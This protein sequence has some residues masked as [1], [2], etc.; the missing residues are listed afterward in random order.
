MDARLSA[1]AWIL[2]SGCFGA[3]VGTLFG[4]VAGAL[5]WRSGR[6]SGTRLSLGFAETVRRFAGREFSRPAKG[7]LIGA[8]DGFLFLG[9]VGTVVGALAVYGGRPPADLLWPAM[10]LTL[11]LVGLAAFFG[12]LAYTLTR[13]GVRGLAPVAC[14]GVLGAAL[15]W[16]Q[17]GVGGLL[18][19]A[20]AGIAVGNVLGLLWPRR[21]EPEFHAPR[22]EMD[23]PYPNGP[24]DGIQGPPGVERPPE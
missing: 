17:G 13:A 18:Y 20:I 4:A 15:G 14:G 5:Y 12:L 7:A 3:V 21:Y 10:Y 6:A 24:E 1:F 2:A 22:L 9:G 16:S 11:L 19:G 8:V 23:A